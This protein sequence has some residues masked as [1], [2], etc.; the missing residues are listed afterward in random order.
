MLILASASPRRR[1]LLARLGLPFEVV[2][3]AVEEG[4]LRGRPERVARRL[5]AA[6]ARA[7]S[8]ERP[9][10]TVLAADTVVAHRGVLLG[11]PRDAAEAEAT[12]KRLRGRA[13]RVVTAVA[14]LPP[15]RR[16]PLLDHAATRV[17]MR[18]YSDAEIAAS[19][20]RGDP[21]DKAGAYAIQDERLAPVARYDA[22]PS[23]RRGAAC[24]ARIRHPVARFGS[25]PAET[26]GCYCNVMGLPLWTAVR[27][28]GRAGLDITR[29]SAGDLPAQCR[30]CTLHCAPVGR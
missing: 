8:E 6:K 20:A 1:E 23:P 27:L 5:A 11:K 9:D 2:E 26:R 30:S 14:V 21:F 16:R 3:P 22:V 24:R 12:L 28:L 29:I 7:V 19:I 13:H 17:T 18:R 25:L 4:N 15:G 10:A